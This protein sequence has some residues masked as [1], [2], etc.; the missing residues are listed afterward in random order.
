MNEFSRV[1]ILVNNAGISLYRPIL[2]CSEADWDNHVDIMAKG[3]F[4]MMRGGRRPS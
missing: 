4:L 3:T 1:D 2:D